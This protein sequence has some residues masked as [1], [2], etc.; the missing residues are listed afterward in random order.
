MTTKTTCSLPDTCYCDDC[1]EAQER[2]G[3]EEREASAANDGVSRFI[4]R[5]HS[6]DLVKAI[7]QD[8]RTLQQGFTILCVAWL[9]HLATLPEGQYDLRNAASVDL[10]R[11]ITKTTEWQEHSGLPYI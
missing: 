10:A 11:A 8:H 5:N 3:N 1:L 9:E 4:N 2:R 7:A 6:S